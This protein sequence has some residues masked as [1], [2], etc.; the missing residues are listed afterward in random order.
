MSYAI[1][2]WTSKNTP[3]PYNT[4]LTRPRHKLSAILSATNLARLH[5]PQREIYTHT[6]MDQLTKPIAVRETTSS[7]PQPPFANTTASPSWHS[8][9]LLSPHQDCSMHCMQSD[10]HLLSCHILAS[11]RTPPVALNTSG[12]DWLLLVG[13]KRGVLVDFASRM[14]DSGLGVVRASLPW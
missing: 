13:G 3:T 12:F 7:T 1:H 14:G 2:T 11:A 6:R 4:H 8:P 9:A 5:T 10:A